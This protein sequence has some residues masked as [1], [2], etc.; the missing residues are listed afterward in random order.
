MVVI[1]PSY[2]QEILQ[3]AMVISVAPHGLIRNSDD[4]YSGG[5]IRPGVLVGWRGRRRQQ[6]QLTWESTTNRRS[7][8][9]KHRAP[10]STTSV[11]VADQGWT[12]TLWRFVTPSWVHGVAAGRP[13]QKYLKGSASAWDGSGSGFTRPWAMKD[14]D[15]VAP[16]PVSHQRGVVD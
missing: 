13:S 5:S 7:F 4:G 10:D 2:Q 9:R 15:P 8:W 16:T 1:S 11:G 3:A 12:W 14:L 6:L